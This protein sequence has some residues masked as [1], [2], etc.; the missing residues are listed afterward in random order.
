LGVGIQTIKN[1]ASGETKLTP[2]VRAG[3]M[4]IAKRAY[5][6]SLQDYNTLRLNFVDRSRSGGL[7]A[8]AVVP[9]GEAVPFEKLYPDLNIG[10]K[11]QINPDIP[12]GM[13]LLRN[14]KTGET[15]LVPIG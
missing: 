9:Y 8:D 7:N 10:G 14:K 5:D 13:Q 11:P 4:R 2:E 6:S 3:M 15:K 12:A 1:A